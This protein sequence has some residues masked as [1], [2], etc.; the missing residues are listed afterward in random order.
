VR[1]HQP[2]VV[3]NAEEIKSLL[4]RNRLTVE[5]CATIPPN[6]L[7]DEIG[8]ADA[9]LLS[10][11]KVNQGKLIHPRPVHKLGFRLD[12]LA[13]L[14]EFGDSTISTTAF[15]QFLHETGRV[16]ESEYRRACDY[17]FAHDQDR[18]ESYVS[19]ASIAERPFYLNHLSA[20]YLLH[21]GLLKPQYLPELD[22]R[23][24]PSLRSYQEDL[25]EANRNGVQI[26]EMLDGIRVRLR[27]ALKDG[28]ATL[29]PRRREAKNELISDS[30]LEFL[31]NESSFDAFCV[32]DRYFNRSSQLL[33]PNGRT[34]PTISAIDIIDYLEHCGT[35]GNKHQVLHRMRAAGFS[36]IHIEAGELQ[37]IL[38]TAHWNAK[39][40]I[41]ESEEMRV[42]RQTLMRTRSLKIIQQPLE[43]SFLDMLLRASLLVIRAVWENRQYSDQQASALSE[44][45]WMN[46][47]PSP[48]DW[49]SANESESQESAW[50]Q[51]RAQ[52]VALILSVGSIFEQTRMNAFHA[53]V[54]RTVLDPMK[55]ANSSLHDAVVKLVKADIERLSDEVTKDSE[56][57]GD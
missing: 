28:V 46:V 14:Q 31:G 11:A 22:I 51:A 34:V 8:I 18:T 1:Y 27:D 50:R 43:T 12:V 16:S 33:S 41:V 13:N 35:I 17:L 30:L 44:W 25:I 2:S 36:L 26:A 19:D 10:S 32:D 24:H 48:L 29:L 20:T 15:A 53:W 9:D 40:Q 49:N 45:I 52:H 39:A 56:S 38:R 21:A 55:P 6:W 54:E 3:R 7:V 4:D 23:V 5:N 47:T 42:L 57:G 37:E